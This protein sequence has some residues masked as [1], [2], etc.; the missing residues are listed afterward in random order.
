MF[1]RKKSKKSRMAQITSTFIFWLVVVLGLNAC[2]TKAASTPYPTKNPVIGKVVKIQN[3]VNLN[4]TT[5]LSVNDHVSL[6]DTIHTLKDARI[7]LLLIDGTIVTLGQNTAL[8]LNQYDFQPKL[9][10]GELLFEIKKGD[11]EIKTGKISKQKK[12]LFRIRTAMAIVG[13]RGTTFWGGSL[14]GITF[15]LALLE[16]QSVL[17]S[18]QGGAVEITEIGFGTTIRNFE[19]APSKPKKWPQQKI[20]RALDTVAFN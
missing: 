1:F 2:S 18:N 15:D 7:K 5:Q 16:G 20:N 17:I 3:S 6:K 4:Q 10:K 19:T 13:V 11:F 12:R 9:D 8:V 14:D